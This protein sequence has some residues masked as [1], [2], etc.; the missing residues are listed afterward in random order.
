[1]PKP[2]G[3]V[4]IDEI[5]AAYYAVIKFRGTWREKNFSKQDNLLR[6]YLDT[7][8]ISII[9]KQFI[10]RYNPPFIPAFLRHNEILYQIDY[11]K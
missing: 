8:N 5:N 1:V 4:Y 7:H 6:T 9:S 11:K 2:L 10:M 3:D